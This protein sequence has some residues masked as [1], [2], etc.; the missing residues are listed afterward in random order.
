[1]A[2]LTNEQLL[3]QEWENK[4]RNNDDTPIH[5][6]FFPFGKNSVQ[7]HD[8]AIA[9]FKHAFEILDMGPHDVMNYLNKDLIEALYLKQAYSK[10]IFPEEVGERSNYGY[11]AKL[12]WPDELPE[13]NRDNLWL[14]DYHKLLSGGSFKRKLFLGSTGFLRARFYLNWYLVMHPDKRFVDLESTYAFFAND[15]KAMAYLKK[16]K[17]NNVCEMLYDSPLEYFHESLPDDGD[18][19]SRNEELFE[20]YKKIRQRNIEKNNA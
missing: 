16:A 14:A 6:T 3:I 20:K 18:E 13:L 2:T 10:I 1:M 19:F 5:R 4:I 15:S 7:N 8:L 11:L 9:L 12:C 17:L